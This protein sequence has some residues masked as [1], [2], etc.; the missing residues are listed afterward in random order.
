MWWGVCLCVIYSK[1]A[2]TPPLAIYNQEVSDT[3]DGLLHMAVALIVRWPV[4][5]TAKLPFSEVIF[6]LIAGCLCFT[7]SAYEF[8]KSICRPLG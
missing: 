4:A 2:R 6:S 8:P 1:L 7:I 3:Q 5:L